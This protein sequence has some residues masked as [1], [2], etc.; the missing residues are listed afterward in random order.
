MAEE[1]KNFSEELNFE[2]NGEFNCYFINYQMHGFYENMPTVI[3]ANRKLT[4]TISGLIPV[5]SAYQEVTE[6]KMNTCFE[7]L[8]ELNLERKNFYKQILLLVKN[9]KSFTIND[10]F[11]VHLKSKEPND[12]L[13][14]LKPEL[15]QLSDLNLAKLTIKKNGFMELKFYHLFKTKNDLLNV[16]EQIFKIKSCMLT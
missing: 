6:I 10:K 9:Q 11:I 13:E 16:L 1:V 7:S 3:K 5:K 14:K 2:L 15:R 12:K 8:N 4:N